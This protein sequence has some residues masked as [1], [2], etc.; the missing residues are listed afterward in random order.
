[1]SCQLTSNVS[2]DCRENLGGI[3]TI[4]LASATGDDISLGFSGGTTNINGAV[5]GVTWGSASVEDLTTLG[6]NTFEFQQPRQAASLTETGNFSEE[7]GTIFYQSVLSMVVN[8]L[9]YAKLD[10]L[11]ALGQNTKLICI[12]QTN[13]D[14][15]YLVGNETGGIVTSSTAETGTS[16]GDRNG[17]TIEI[18][19]FSKNPAYQLILA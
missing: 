7:N 5:T 15:Y 10:A 2:L 9:G 14:D 1:M 3:K 4:F 16:F 17:L 8:K 6:E 18:T 12:V 13:N 19:G 11:R